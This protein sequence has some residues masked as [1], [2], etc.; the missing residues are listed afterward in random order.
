M[1]GK[2]QWSI[3]S[4]MVIVLLAAL[5]CGF[6]RAILTA[7]NTYWQW[8]FFE[9]PMINIL[10]LGL[11]RMRAEPESRRFWWTFEIIGWSFT[12]IL[13]VIGWFDLNVVV[14]PLKVCLYPLGLLTWKP[15]NAEE[16]AIELLGILLIYGVLPALLAAI[17]GWF[18]DGYRIRIAIVRRPRSDSIAILDPSIQT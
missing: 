4:L 3:G 8:I 7:S 2:R 16:I 5:D 9:V 10:I 17:V 1:A 13:F 11:L 6:F 12:T 14:L 15:S 18:R